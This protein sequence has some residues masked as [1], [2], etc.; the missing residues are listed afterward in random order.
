MQLLKERFKFFY[1]GKHDFHRYMFRISF[2]L[3]IKSSKKFGEFISF[4]RFNSKT[5]IPNTEKLF[6][7]F[8]TGTYMFRWTKVIPK[9]TKHLAKIVNGF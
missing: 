8:A 3:T 5:I 7:S 2:R 4:K 6:G 1:I 9:K